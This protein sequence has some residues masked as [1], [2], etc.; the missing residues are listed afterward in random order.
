MPKAKT[1][2][3]QEV[4]EVVEYELSAPQ[5]DVLTSRASIIA[6]IAGQGGG[7][8]VN[9]GISVGWL[10]QEFPDAKGFI[11]ANTHMQLNHSTLSRVF[12]D[13]EKYY[14]LTEWD[15]D[16]NPGGDYVYDVKPP[17]YWKKSEYKFKKYQ[18]ILSFK[19]G[20]RVFLGSL[21]NYKAHDG[22]E[23]AWAHLDETKDTAR[24]ALTDVILGRLRQVGLWV[25][26]EGKVIWAPKVTPEVA[27]RTGL[28]SWNPLYIHTSP[29]EG[30]V[31]WLVDLLGI[32]PY[33]QEI[34]ERIV[35]KDDY[36][37]KRLVVKEPESGHETET[38][39][40]IYSAYWNEHNLPPSYLPGKKARMSS[41]EQLKFIY[42]YPFGRNG[43]EY[44]PGFSRFKQV[45]KYPY[46]PGKAI[47]TTWD[48]NA[49]PYVTLL[50][51]H[52][53]YVTRFWHEEEKKK[54]N[55]W[56]EGTRPMEVLK[57]RVFKAYNTP[58]PRNTT[59]Q[60]AD[61]FADDF[62][63]DSPDVFANGDAS[64]HSRIEGL[65]TLTQYK[66]IKR[67][68]EGR[69]YLAEGWLRAPRVNIALNKRRDL[70][71]R[72]WEGRLPE[73][74]IEIDESCVNLVRD[75]EYLLYDPKTGGKLKETEEDANG[76]KIQKLGHNADALEYLVC[77]LCIHHL[78]D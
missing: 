18:N 49:S 69:I 2:K 27:K 3:P 5:N 19:N 59:E 57:I 72:I 34:R 62:E 66:I 29:A 16:T 52:V 45:G 48:F 76:I 14:G 8:T 30:N 47:A 4:E 67:Q 36:F 1:V 12:H 7:K 61:D 10:V 77:P 73:V 54:Y 9:I 74:E 26:K 42:G 39:V 21:D 22:K 28:K 15:K 55:E 43:G 60:T 78:K 56:R 68:W 65:G 24:E 51:C 53:E 41:S 64:G 6:D 35:R 50:C 32:A 23:F 13:L 63:K 75:C 70:M 46:E 71:N 58:E 20:A 37:F 40:V 38:D 25:T 44:Y 31:D 33:E 17:R 11:A